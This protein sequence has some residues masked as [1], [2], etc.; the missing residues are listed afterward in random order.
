[1]PRMIG[2]GLSRREREILDVLYRLGRASVGDVQAEMAAAPSYSA[3]RALLGILEEKGHVRHVEDG[4]RYLYTPTEAPKRAA[5]SALQQVV[6]T[7]FAGSLELAVAAFLSDS[8][9]VAPEELDR[10]QR[11]I[12]EAQ[13]REER[14]RPAPE[15]QT[16]SPEE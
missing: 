11:V 7:F 14:G 5:R 4:K 9:K 13:A 2:S 3:V 8:E 6:Q 16:D 15:A 12:A 10:L 1:M